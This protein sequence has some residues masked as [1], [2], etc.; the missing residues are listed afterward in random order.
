MLGA[1]L[2]RGFMGQKYIFSG[3]AIALLVC[4]FSTFC[5]LP[6]KSNS[7]DL[8]HIVSTDDFLGPYSSEDLAPSEI[9]L[10]NLRQHGVQNTARISQFG[11]G[12]TIQV[13]QTG[14]NNMSDVYQDGGNNFI[15][16]HQTGERNQLET[17][18]Q[19]DNNQ[20]L[21][22]QAGQDNFLQF[23]QEGNGLSCTVTQMGVSGATLIT[24][25]SH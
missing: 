12:D 5:S 14:V 21:L 13:W 7:A 8:Q 16:A 4:I 15:L 23:G 25:F 24:Q 19:G 9:N 1:K 3:P 20:A 6:T 10:V 17:T 2:K 11:T 18:Q 22:L